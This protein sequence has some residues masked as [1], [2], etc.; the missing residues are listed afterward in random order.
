MARV[1]PRL[2][3]TRAWITLNDATPIY[4]TEVQNDSA[5]DLSLVDFNVHDAQYGDVLALTVGLGEEDE[6]IIPAG[7]HRAASSYAFETTG[8]VHSEGERPLSSLQV[9]WTSA[10]PVVGQRKDCVNTPYGG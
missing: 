1:F 8:L 6:L 2:R 3:I 9:D 4:W 5:C 7:G 10:L